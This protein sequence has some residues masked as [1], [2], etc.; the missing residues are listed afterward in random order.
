MCNIVVVHNLRYRKRALS[1]HKQ[2]AHELPIFAWV[3]TLFV[4]PATGYEHHLV[5]D[6]Q[7]CVDV[8][9]EYTPIKIA[10]RRENV[11]FDDDG[12]IDVSE[13]MEHVPQPA[14]GSRCLVASS[15]SALMI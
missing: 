8:S 3:W 15:V 10:P 7:T 9:S 5:K 12:K 4:A 1:R 11:N 14:V 13:D 6:S 2:S